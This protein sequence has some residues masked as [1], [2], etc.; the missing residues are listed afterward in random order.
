VPRAGVGHRGFQRDRCGPQHDQPRFDGTM[1]LRASAR[2]SHPPA[3]RRRTQTKDV[4]E[5]GLLEAFATLVPS[6]ISGDPET[7]LLWVSKSQRHL[8]GALALALPSVRS[9]SDGYC[10]AWA[11]ACKR[12][13]RRA[14]ARTTPTVTRS[15]NTSTRGSTRSRRPGTPA[16][17]VQAIAI[18]RPSRSA[19]PRLGLNAI[20]VLGRAMMRSALADLNWRA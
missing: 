7:G 11:S 16:L 14:R 12:T 20:E 10:A 18:Q 6:A 2:A 17:W 5:P 13:A 4:T 19:V 15:S 9:W 3:R 8:A 1:Q